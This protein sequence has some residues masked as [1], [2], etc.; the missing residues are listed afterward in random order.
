M[1]V[2]YCIKPYRFLKWGGVVR[3]FF[4]W[5]KRAEGVKDSKSPQQKSLYTPGDHKY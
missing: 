5:E 3:I 2:L 1:I 4:L